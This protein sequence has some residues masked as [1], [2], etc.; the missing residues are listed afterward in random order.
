MTHDEAKAS[1][2]SCA[3]AGCPVRFGERVPCV[4]VAGKPYCGPHAYEARKAP[5][6][7]PAVVVAPPATRPMRLVYVA[8]PITHGNQFANV[9]RAILA[10]HQLRR[11]GIVPIVPHLSALFEI[12]FGEHSYEEWMAEDFAFIA[13]CHALLRLPGKSEGADREVVEAR[14]LELPVFLDIAECVRWAST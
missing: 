3:S 9:H 14:R 4:I 13:V 1:G 7:V 11:A 2:A 12:A 8:G 5:V 10:G 6:A